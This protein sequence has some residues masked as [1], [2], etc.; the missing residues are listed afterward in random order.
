MSGELTMVVPPGALADA[1]AVVTSSTAELREQLQTSAWGDP[2]SDSEHT[3]H[4]YLRVTWAARVA[5]AV[6]L[7]RVE[8][9]GLVIGQP[10][11]EEERKSVA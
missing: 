1:Y 6:A 3:I 2:G 11:P 10:V 7:A 8:L 9:A 5:A 4:L